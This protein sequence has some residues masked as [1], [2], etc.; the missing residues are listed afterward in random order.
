MRSKNSDLKKMLIS[1]Q[2]NNFI[3]W[4]AHS[5]PPLHLNADLS[6]L[7]RY[8]KTGV[9]FV[10]LNIGFDL[11]SQTELLSFL[12]YSSQWIK[13]HYE[14]YAVVNNTNQIIENKANNKLS[15]AFDIEGCNFLNNNLDLIPI[16]YGFGVKQISFS[17][18]K[19]NSAGGGCLDEDSGLTKFGKQLIKKFNETGIV[20][21]CSHVGP[22]TS[23][24]IIELSE[25][26]IVFS[27]SNPIEICPH[28]RNITNTQ[29]IECAKKG[30]IIGINGIGIFLGNNDTS[31]NKIVDHIEFI[32]EKAGISHVGIGLDCI[33]DS[34]EMKTYVKDNPTI[35]PNSLG[36]DNVKVAEPEQFSEIRHLLT[37]RGYKQN[38]INSVMGGNFLRIANLV[39]K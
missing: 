24:E 20:I 3:N 34:T 36:F 31:T 8:K 12:N 29:I 14:D 10:S 18:N 32:I 16:L 21:D 30:G 33:F 1:S 6:F 37:C 13:D 22:K 27:H 23:L 11:N 7:S 4:D 17:Y 15:I 25:Y 39:W 5:C 35:F 28:P 19:N 9:D 26:P 2:S 38:E